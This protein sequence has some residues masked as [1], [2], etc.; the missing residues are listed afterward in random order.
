MF[1]TLRKNKCLSFNQK[2]YH[3]KIPCNGGHQFTQNDVHHDHPISSSFFVQ[4]R[5]GFLPSHLDERFV[6]IRY[7]AVGLRDPDK[8]FD[9]LIGELVLA[10]LVGVICHHITPTFC[11]ESLNIYL[12]DKFD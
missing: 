8:A 11:G 7:V 12:L 3:N 9:D 5:D 2:K 6:L 10:A 4:I 1:S